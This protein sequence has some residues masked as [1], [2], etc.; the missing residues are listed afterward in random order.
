[1]PVRAN[2]VGEP[3]RYAA[4]RD[5]VKRCFRRVDTNRDRYDYESVCRFQHKYGTT[6]TLKSPDTAGGLFQGYRG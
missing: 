4:D 1:M 2:D 6:I 3:R 5:G